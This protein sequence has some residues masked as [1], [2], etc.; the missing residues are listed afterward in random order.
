MTYL[1]KRLKIG[2]WKK[3][4][5]LSLL[6]ASTIG[7]TYLVSPNEQDSAGAVFS[8]NLSFFFPMLIVSSLL[9]IAA[10]LYLIRFGRNLKDYEIKYRKQKVLATLLFL[11][12]FLFHCLKIPV[13]L[14]SITFGY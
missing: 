2:V 9:G 8:Y 6:S 11:I 4:F 10:I 12:P 13:F 7:W 14:M 5:V 1:S 3:S